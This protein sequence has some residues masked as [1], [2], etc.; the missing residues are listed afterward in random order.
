MIPVYDMLKHGSVREVNTEIEEFQNT[1]FIR[2]RAKR[3]I[4]SGQELYLSYTHYPGSESFR[5]YYGTPEL[6]ADKGIIEYFPQ[7]W[8][9]TFKHLAFQMDQVG[10]Y[11]RISWIFAKPSSKAKTFLDDAIAALESFYSNNLEEN[12]KKVPDSEWRAIQN[13]YEA[14]LAAL[15]SA[16]TALDDPNTCVMAKGDCPETYFDDLAEQPEPL[17]RELYVY[18]CDA[19]KT[20]EFKGYVSLDQ[21]ESHYQFLEFDYHPKTNDIVFT[22]DG[23]IQQ[24]TGFR[25]HYHE[26][27]V[28][29]TARYIDDVKRVM[30]IGGGDSMLLH[31]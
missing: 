20:H 13:Y 11:I 2:V 7:R 18:T 25:P 10:E 24:T 19:Q 16:L 4:E 17:E 6:F 21:V 5:H 26:P 9:F 8:I 15:I 28:H 27:F 30:W 1:P 22:L 29:Y 12:S 14:L 31:E 3:A 23:I